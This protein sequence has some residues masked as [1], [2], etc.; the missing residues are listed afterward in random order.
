[1]NDSKLASKDLIT[2][3]VFSVVFFAL[4][5]VSALLAMVFVLY[6]FAPALQILFCGIVW[7]YIRAKVPKRF[8]ILMQCGI[9]ALLILLTGTLWTIPAGMLAG[10]VLAEL[11][12]GRGA[13][14]NFKLCVAAYAVYGLCFNFSVFGLILLARDYWYASVTRAGMQVEYMEKV[15]ALISW[16][17]LGVSSAVTLAAAVLGMVFGRF[18][19]KKHFQRA[20]IV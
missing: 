1:M 5:R 13:H 12:S 20:G 4:M 3:A 8:S 7:M 19:L 9:M 6:P 11:V 10:G 2:I 18:M 17:L 14:K 15:A 16:P